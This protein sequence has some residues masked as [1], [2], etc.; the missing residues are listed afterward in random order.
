MT[1]KCNVGSPIQFLK[2]MKNT[3]ETVGNIDYGLSGFPN[4][5]SAL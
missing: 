5:V 3:I 1:I 2:F 4:A